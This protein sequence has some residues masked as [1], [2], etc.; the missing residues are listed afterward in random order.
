MC[1]GQRPLS[2]LAHGSHCSV[3]AQPP[4][5]P[6]ASSL[7]SKADQRP[8]P[9]LKGSLHQALPPSPPAATESNL[10]AIFTLTAASSR[11]GHRGRTVWGGQRSLGWAGPKDAW[12]KALVKKPERV[13]G[14]QQERGEGSAQAHEL[15]ERVRASVW[16][17]PDF[18]RFGS[19]CGSGCGFHL[20][21]GGLVWLNR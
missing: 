3:G 18:S 15:G 2:S 10:T 14:L 17:Q 8:M 9:S 19:I 7:G 12:W 1:G 6:G 5:G 13:Q 4:T 20:E 16:M 11:S 21:A